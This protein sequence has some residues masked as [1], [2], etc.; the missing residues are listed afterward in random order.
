MRANSERTCVCLCSTIKERAYVCEINGRIESLLSV[1][2]VHRLTR[3]YMYTR[4]LAGC[5]CV[6]A[7]EPRD[8]GTPHGHREKRRQARLQKGTS[9]NSGGIQ[10]VYHVPSRYVAHVYRRMVCENRASP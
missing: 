4:P 2:S 3:M 7:G 8:G 5:L 9:M 1:S 10:Y 6:C